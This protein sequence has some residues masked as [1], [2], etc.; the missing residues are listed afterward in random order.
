M[1]FR[2]TAVLALA[3]ASV[4][5]LVNQPRA[6]HNDLAARAA[7]LDARDMSLHSLEARTF[8][9]GCGLF[10]SPCLDGC[11][12]WLHSCCC[13][14]IGKWGQVECGNRCVPRGTPCCGGKEG[15]VQCGNSCIPKGGNCCGGRCNYKEC[16]GKC[17]PENQ[18]CCD[19]SKNQQCGNQCIP[20]DRACCN[21]Q[22]D[23]VKC[24]DSCVAPGTSCCGGKPGQK[25][26][27]GGCIAD[28][29]SCC[30][31]STSKMCNGQ[32]VPK[33]QQ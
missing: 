21:G 17:I 9:G 3:V 26:C 19:L 18:Q 24:G 22:P 2:V 27:N 33:D 32:C 15:W 28:S 29:E 4:Q 5:G 20:K 13:D 30:D 25:P 31:S 16:N 12:W 7:E 11:R 10:K 23:K 8:F 14:N 6:E 1:L